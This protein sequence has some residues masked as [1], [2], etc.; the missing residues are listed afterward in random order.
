MTA[1][2]AHIGWPVFNLTGLINKV[3]T[4]SVTLQTVPA[5]DPASVFLFLVTHITMSA[6]ISVLTVI[7]CNSRREIPAGFVF[8]MVPVPAD[9]L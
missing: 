2:V 5:G 7:R 1:V 4:E 9:F 3:R 6:G 8:L